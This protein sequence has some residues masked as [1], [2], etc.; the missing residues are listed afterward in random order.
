MRVGQETCASWPRHIRVLSNIQ[1]FYVLDQVSTQTRKHEVT[2]L[3]NRIEGQFPGAEP[4][5]K[6]ITWLIR[7]LTM[8][9]TSEADG[10]QQRSARGSAN[11]KKKKQRVDDGRVV[12]AAM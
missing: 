11:R 5:R 2:A 4:H 6:H 10:F 7:E 9:L 1:I 8:E 3:Q 12:Q